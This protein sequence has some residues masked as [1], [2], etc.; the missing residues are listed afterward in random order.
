MTR[1]NITETLIAEYAAQQDRFTFVC[2]LC[3][4]TVTEYDDNAKVR[5][6]VDSTEYHLDCG[7]GTRSHDGHGN[8]I[9]L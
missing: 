8:R 9:T 1:P 5:A 6:L 7:A 3:D 4:V 2:D